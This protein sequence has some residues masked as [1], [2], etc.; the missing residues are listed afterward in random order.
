MLFT[1]INFQSKMSQ[2]KADIESELAGN[3]LCVLADIAMQISPTSMGVGIAHSWSCIGNCQCR[4][5][6]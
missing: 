1:F 2:A 3:P 5:E 6:G 4:N